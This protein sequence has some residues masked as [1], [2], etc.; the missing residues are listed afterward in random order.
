MIPEPDV[1]KLL[2]LMYE[3]GFKMGGQKM[4]D[5]IKTV[6]EMLAALA[7]IYEERGKVYG[8]DYKNHGKVMVALFPNGLTLKSVDDFNRYSCFKELITKTSRYAPN[9]V[10]GGHA[11]S[12]DDISVYSQMLQELDANVN[13]K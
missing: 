9:F 2:L 10:K 7:R 4:D 5:G 1:A 12:L 13:K 11:D 3:L 8:D 6:P